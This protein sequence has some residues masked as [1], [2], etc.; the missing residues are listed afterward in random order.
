MRSDIIGDNTTGN[1]F[2]LGYGLTQ[3]KILA[4]EAGHYFNLM[5]IFE[6]R[7]AGANAAT[8]TSDQCG[9]TVI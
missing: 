3:G 6:G 1:A 4:H 5:H 2:S 8:T 7:C 9:L